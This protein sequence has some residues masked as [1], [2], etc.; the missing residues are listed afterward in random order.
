MNNAVLKAVC[1]NNDG[2][3]IDLY[4]ISIIL[5]N[6]IISSEYVPPISLDNSIVL[7]SQGEEWVGK[8]REGISNITIQEIKLAMLI[9]FHNKEFLIDISKTDFEK[10]F[11]IISQEIISGMIRFPWIYERLLYDKFFELFPH[12]PDSFTFEETQQILTDTPVG[13]FQRGQ[14]VIGPYGILRS[15]QK[16]NLPIKYSAPMWHCSDITCSTIHWVHFKSQY[17]YSAI[18]KASSLIS[19][20]LELPD[21]IINLIKEY[22]AES[23]Y[24]DHIQLDNLHYL[25]INEFSESELRSLLGKLIEKHSKDIRS[26][27]PK[28]LAKGSSSQIVDKLNL[29][30][31]FQLILLM[32]N[33]SIANAVEELIDEEIII[34][35]STEIRVSRFNYKKLKGYFKNI[36]EC[37]QF[38]IRSISSKKDLSVIRLKILIK[39]LYPDLNE[40]WRISLIDGKDIEEKLNNYLLTED[41][42]KIV[43]ETI[44]TSPNNIRRTEEFFKYGNFN[45][46]RNVEEE[47]KLIKKVLWKLGFN[48][49]LFPIY[50]S[51]F[52]SRYE[53]LLTSIRK[54]RSYTEHDREEIRSNAV[55]FFVSLEEILDLTLTFSTW[56]LLSDHTK[57]KLRFDLNK[58]RQFMSDNLSSL[59]DT[60][61]GFVMYDKDGKNTLYPLIEGFDILAERCE[62]Y[63]LKK[64]GF[65]RNK[66]ELPDYSDATNVMLFPFRHYNYVLDI[67]EPDLEKI[68]NLLTETT[69]VL[70]QMKVCDV[71]N[72]IEHK[73]M[74]FPLQEDIENACKAIDS[75]IT[76]LEMAG[77]CPLISL[78]SG[79]SLDQFGRGY[80]ILKNYREEETRIFNSQFDPCKLPSSRVPQIVV[81]SVRLTGSSENIRFAYEETSENTKKWTNYPKRLPT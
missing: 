3:I 13:V 67:Q 70:T 25:L 9:N 41:P 55:N 75:V 38:G 21:N 59:R 2:I 78:Y 50:N 33:I 22:H 29:A 46:P 71:R 15:K 36:C 66:D 76:K 30:Q 52:W 72:R 32:D 57:T 54:Y 20:N 45:L 73:R 64:E 74:D 81:H 51:L 16:R 1:A 17:A 60:G 7:T 23:D 37:S 12:K 19:K 39:E 56:M 26:L 35:P 61:K 49:N 69:A 27:M 43:K 11:E 53:K 68:L 80:N 77:L 48:I 18:S 6:S 63:L 14:I 24:F 10:V 42:I 8:I 79:S 31:I 28:S 40:L 34:I 58:S 47:E 44:F 4:Q 65:I 62:E 5:R